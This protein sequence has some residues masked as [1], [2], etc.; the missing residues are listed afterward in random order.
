MQ[1]LE[2]IISKVIEVDDERFPLGNVYLVNDY[3]HKMLLFG[4]NE[5]IE[6]IEDLVEERVITGQRLEL[7]YLPG[8][9]DLLPEVVVGNEHINN[10]LQVEEL[11]NFPED[12]VRYIF[13]FDLNH[14]II[15]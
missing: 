8:K 5:R 2:F 3:L 1:Q 15:K 10:V 12:F 4:K 14:I 9:K 7:R 13:F 11:Y 6:D